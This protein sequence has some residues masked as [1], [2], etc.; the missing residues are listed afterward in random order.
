MAIIRARR[1]LSIGKGIG[2]RRAAV[3]SDQSA[4]RNF[5]VVC[6]GTLARHIKK[7]NLA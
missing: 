5:D 3:I 1:H 7:I 6:C 4:N 2:A